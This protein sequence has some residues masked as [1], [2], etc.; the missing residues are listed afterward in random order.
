MLEGKVPIQEKFLRGNLYTYMRI[1]GSHLNEREH[2][3]MKASG[4]NM[5]RIMVAFLNWNR[6]ILI[7]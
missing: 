1:Y 4:I 7:L 5:R 3:H 2:A 6:Y